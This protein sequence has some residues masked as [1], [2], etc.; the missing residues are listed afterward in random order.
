MRGDRS[1][2]PDVEATERPVRQLVEAG[3]HDDATTAL[4]RAHAADVYGFLHIARAAG[5]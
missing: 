4:V 3:R 1:E 5:S 2:G